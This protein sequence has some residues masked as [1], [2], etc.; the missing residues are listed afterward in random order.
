MTRYTVTHTDGREV[1]IVRDLDY[2]TAL[3]LVERDTNAGRSAWMAE[4]P[5]SKRGIER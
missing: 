2:W 3:R 5:S 1:E 4:Q